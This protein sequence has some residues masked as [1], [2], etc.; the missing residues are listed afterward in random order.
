MRQGARG[1]PVRAGVYAMTGGGARHRR[2]ARPMSLVYAGVLSHGPGITG[3][4]DLVE[5]VAA[6]RA[7]RGL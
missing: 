3:R 6:R 2:G 1:M 7:L 4:A 5:N